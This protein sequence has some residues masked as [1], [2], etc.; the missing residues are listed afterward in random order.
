MKSSLRLETDFSYGKTNIKD[1]YFE[2]PYKIMSPFVQEDCT[3]VMQMCASAG[4]LSGDMFDLELKIGE[5]SNLLYT[6]QSYE[7]VFASKGEKTIK[8]TR[9][10]VEKEAR[11]LYM[12]K[13]VI[14]FAH[15]DFMGENEIHLDPSS[16]FLYCDIF[17]CG[18]VAMGERFQ[19]K[20]YQ[21]KTRIYV[22][23]ILAMAD[24]TLLDP[25]WFAYDT[26]GLWNNYTHNGLLYLYTPDGEQK[27]RWIQMI[28]DKKP[29]QVEA[30]CSECRQGILLRV[31]GKSGD[32]VY[33]YFED[34]VREV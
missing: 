8:R 12:P 4:M 22:G 26:L 13:P 16:S 34:I 31:L 19:M 32:A 23:D 9:I 29:D 17:N 28:R 27:S 14:P 25:S 5:H 33:D 20:R 2:A 18:R 10:R 24:H 7:K 21:S 11:L 30:G 6:S 15:S 1:I 3:E